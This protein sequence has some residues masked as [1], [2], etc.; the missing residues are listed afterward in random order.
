MVCT[1]AEASH[2]P[3]TKVRISGERERDMT[4][5]VWPVYV[6]HCCPV[7]MSQSALKKLKREVAVTWLQMFRGMML[8]KST[9]QVMSPLLVTIWLSSRNRQQLRYPV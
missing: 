7:S 2:A 1:F 3:E 9:H 4:S 5:P 6:V 8:V